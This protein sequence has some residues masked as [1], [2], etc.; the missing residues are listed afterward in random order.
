MEELTLSF[1]TRINV[2]LS[3]G[4][5][6]YFIS[7]G[8]TTKLGIVTTVATDGLSFNLNRSL[9]DPVPSTT[10]Y[11]FFSKPAEIESSGIIGY[12]A[13]TTLVNTSTKRA[14]LYAVSSEVFQ[15]S[16]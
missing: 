9:R 15:S 4:D 7:G 6:V 13:T 16:I 3:P 11:I 8:K 12:E 2:S 1:N 14:E 5:T 10:D